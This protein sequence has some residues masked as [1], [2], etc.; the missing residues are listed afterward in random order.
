MGKK[1]LIT[2]LMVLP[3]AVGISAAP[4][5]A[6]KK[7]VK[8]IIATVVL[9]AKN[10]NQM[11]SAI[12]DTVDPNSPTYRQYLSTS[13]FT[14]DYGQ[15]SATINKFKSY[16]KKHHLKTKALD[17]NLVLTVEGSRKNL[18][19]AFDAKRASANHE[20]HYVK[21]KLPKPLSS[22]TL[23]VLGV[24][25]AKSKPKSKALPKVVETGESPSL[26]GNSTT[27]SKK[28]GAQKFTNRYKLSHLI[29]N[30]GDGSGESVGIV[31]LGHYNKSDVKKYL[32]TNGLPADVSRLHNHYVYSS[33]GE[34]KK[35]YSRHVSENR[36]MNQLE[37]SLDVEQSSSVAP[38]ANV[39]VYI[40]DT[41][42][43][44][45][46][47]NAMLYTTFANAISDNQVNQLSTSFGVGN[48]RIKYTPG[49]SGTIKQYNQAFNQLLKQAALQGI[50]VFN[51]SGDYGPYNAQIG[52]ENHDL[53]TGSPYL[54]DVGGTTLPY[55]KVS[56]GK[57]IRV[58]Q[59]RAWG[60]TYSLSES[61]IKAG[62]FPGSGGG[63]SLLNETPG[64]QS[65]VSGVGTYRAIKLLDFK[66]GRYLINKKPKVKTG[67]HSGR[68]FPDVSANSDGKTG[69]AVVASAKTKQNK[70]H[71][72]WVVAGGT[73]FASPQM[74]AANADLNSKLT[75]PIGFW[76]PQI[77]RFAGQSNSPFN[78]LDSANNNNNLYYTG[79][80]GKL[81]NQATGLGTVNFSDLYSKFNE[82]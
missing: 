58:Q 48:E 10:A 63:F 28:Y 18:I 81:Y 35:F 14:K 2:A 74:A 6:S 13:Q 75:Q 21:T 42:N 40:G 33:N 70:N 44:Q 4:A 43:E 46:T 31:A 27:F 68:N 51:A 19:K 15:S 72:I 80:P 61:Q 57:L 64:Y 49:E 7:R 16:F 3:L 60:D 52:P 24:L 55:T 76:N 67:K 26:S 59:E 41:V 65:A 37:V 17:G 25:A 53:P 8:P 11:T 82:G 73:S 32:K 39:D 62:H 50:S 77:Y 34:M 71:T 79:Q 36:F 56:N 12:N 54:T 9:K 22:K 66:H 78:V 23:T 38:N 45:A 1:L 20:Y 69:Y 30:G 29:N 47:G 5:A